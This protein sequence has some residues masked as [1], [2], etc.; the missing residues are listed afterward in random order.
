M[1][2]HILPLV[3]WVMRVGAQIHSVRQTPAA[4]AARAVTPSGR[5]FACLCRDSGGNTS[6]KLSDEFARRFVQNS[7]PPIC[8]RVLARYAGCRCGC[9]HMEHH[10]VSLKASET[11]PEDGRHTTCWFRMSSVHHT[12][13]STGA[14]HI[15]KCSRHRHL[16]SL[17]GRLPAV[18]ATSIAV[19]M[20]RIADE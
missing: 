3:R 8:S 20:H 5:A 10:L 14:T 16:W 1:S 17:L 12:F 15:T 7:R 2:K 11:S 19:V 18:M 9:H 13:I 4:A 6:A